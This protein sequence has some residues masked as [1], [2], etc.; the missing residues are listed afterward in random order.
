MRPWHAKA[1][2]KGRTPLPDSPG[3]RPWLDP[4]NSA[5]AEPA[6][7]E[8]EHEESNETPDQNVAPG[9][10]PAEDTTAAATAS[11]AG[12]ASTSVAA[13]SAA[14]PP[15]SEATASEATSQ[16]YTFWRGD[17]LRRLIEMRNGGAKWS[18]I[19]DAFPDR[20]L[21]ALK[22]TFHKRRHATERR[23]AEEAEENAEGPASDV[24]Q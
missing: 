7:P 13:T 3:S 8:K 6:G 10:D 2:A 20:T 23:M 14:G 12:A 17:D 9:S 11:D 16:S 19:A 4:E 18:A 21:E 24:E 15:T 1:L 5:T 22:Q